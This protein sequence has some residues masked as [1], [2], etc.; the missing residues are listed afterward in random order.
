MVLIKTL[1]FFRDFERSQ[2]SNTES[3]QNDKLIWKD[4]EGPPPLQFHWNIF[5]SIF[6]LVVVHYLSVHEWE[7]EHSK[8]CVKVTNYFLHSVAKTFPGL[9]SSQMMQL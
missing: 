1:Y 3:Q 2:R 4:L 9:L 7:V 5:P 6:V 8:S